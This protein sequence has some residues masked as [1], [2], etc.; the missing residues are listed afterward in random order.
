MAR[1][2]ETTNDGTTIR[3]ERTGSGD[4]VVLVHGITERREV[5]DPLVER[6]AAE[7]EL[8]TLDLRGHGRSDRADRYDLVDLAGDVAAVIADAG[9]GHP[10]V[11]GHSLGGAVVTA[12]GA[13]GGVRSV[14]DID[15]SLRLSAFKDQVGQVEEL[16][17]DPQAFGPVMH[18]LFQELMGPTLPEAERARLTQLRRADQDVVLGVWQVLLE[19]SP[20][21]VDATID[22]ALAGYRRHAVPYLSIFGADPGEGY[23]RWLSARIP[24]ALVELW[25]DHGHYPHLVAPDRMADRLRAFWASP[26]G[27]DTG[28]GTSPG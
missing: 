2:H 27:N 4:P 20:A 1:Q 8:I 7:V 21:E 17:R 18:G 13:A 5:W 3:W 11:V 14:T 25:P 6:L 28:N 12:L 9:V 22:A 10:H 26:A 19:S 15:Q 24:G 16:L 23:Q